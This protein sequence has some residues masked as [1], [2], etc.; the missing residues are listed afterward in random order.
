MSFLEYLGGVPPLQT[1]A[2]CDP[3]TP[4]I[5]SVSHIISGNPKI[6]QSSIREYLDVDG[7]TNCAFLIFNHCNHC[8]KELNLFFFVWFYFLYS[9]H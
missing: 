9:I 8:I 5:L 1:L 3:P 4:P 7:M 2:V 6:G